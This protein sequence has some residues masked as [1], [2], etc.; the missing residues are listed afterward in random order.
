MPWRTKRGRI[1]LALLLLAVVVGGVGW[2]KL[3]R[4]VKGAYPSIVE[5]YKYGSVGVEAA[6][7][8]PY[9]VWAVL[10]EVFADKIDPA[11]YASF[12]FLWEKGHATPIGLPVEVV[13]FQRIGL[14][15]G[16]CHIGSVRTAPDAPRVLL[17][18][19]P[20]STLDLQR[21]FRFLFAAAQDPRFTAD[22]LIPAIA[23]RFDISMLDKMLLRYVI[24]PQTRNGLLEQKQ[25]LWWMDTVPDWGTGR[26]D[27]FNPAKVQ[28]AHLPWDGSIGAAR[29]VPLWNWQARQN[30][31]LHR[32]GLNTSLTEIFL[33]SGIGNGATNKT[34]DLP[35]LRRLQDWV[36]DLKP[37]PYPFPID[38]TLAR[39]GQAVYQAECASCHA[40]GGDK[41]GQPIPIAQLGTDRHRLDSWT[42]QARDAFNGLND[43]DWHYSHFRKTDGY[44]AQALD[45]LWARAPYLHNGSVPSLADLLRPPAERPVTF[46]VGYDVY[47][48][49]H[50][51]FI[52]NGPDAQANGHEF[53]TTL[54]G[55][56]NTGHLYGTAL[57]EDSKRALLEYL[58]TL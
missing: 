24:I 7:G 13:G 46:W 45:G 35:G 15:C 18:G 52:S 5:Y 17:I 42:T 16:L 3:L 12:G 54:L 26:V 43:Y 38:H 51:G 22:T 58:K 55:N 31:G 28:L 14:N 29:M 41:T 48:G 19:A 11:G 32:D 6:S 25:Q 2:Y 9:Q 44:V 36:G 33:N 34:I 30:F 4:Q 49:E 40:F 53:D 23:R 10:P 1:C 37:P 21:Y 57:P 39:R 8:L 56:A 27:P 50:V 20:N 47:D